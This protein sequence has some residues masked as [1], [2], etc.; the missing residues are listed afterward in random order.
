[1][2]GARVLQIVWESLVSNIVFNA[3]KGRINELH[4][5]VVSNDPVNSALIIV[6]LKTAAADAVNVDFD[7][8]A[9]V[10]AGKSSK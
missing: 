9:D 1:M 10:L 8:L 2:S 4:N 7:T 6:L 5:R 3:A